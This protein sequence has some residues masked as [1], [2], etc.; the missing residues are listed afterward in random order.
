[1]KVNKSIKTIFCF[2]EHLSVIEKVK[3]EIDHARFYK[4]S[5][6]MAYFLKTTFWN[7]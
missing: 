1:M 7:L 4:M 5:A 6:Q 3:F 2:A